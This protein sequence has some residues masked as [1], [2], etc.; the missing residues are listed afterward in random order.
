MN[1]T[2]VKTLTAV[3][4]ISLAIAGTTYA[5]ASDNASEP[6]K[7]ATPVFT[8]KAAEVPVAKLNGDSVYPSAAPGEPQVSAIPSFPTVRPHIGGRAFF[9]A[10]LLVM[11]G[12]NA[13]D[14]FSTR[15][16]LRYSG[17]QET[18]PLMKPFVKNAAVF[19]GIKLGT[20]ILSAVSLNTLFKHNRTAAWI[21]TTATNAFLSY[22]VANNMRQIQGARAAALAQ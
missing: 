21:V 17:L 7:T 5:M 10:N 9:T 14:Y 12:L 3:I 1:K 6:A 19:A 16:A 15:T 20:T 13:A 2:M 18:N 11:V 22:V 4:M 8:L